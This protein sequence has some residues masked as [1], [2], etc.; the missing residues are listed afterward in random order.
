MAVLN[1]NAI[2]DNNSTNHNVNKGNIVDDDGVNNNDGNS[3]YNMI[4]TRIRIIATSTKTSTLTSMITLLTKDM[5]L[6][7]SV[8]GGE[9]D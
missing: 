9:P 2:N 4:T 6:A 7:T 3:Y 8:A 1:S 5:S